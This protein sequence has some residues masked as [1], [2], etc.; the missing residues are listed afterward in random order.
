MN[1]LERVENPPDDIIGTVTEILDGDHGLYAVV[2]VRDFCVKWVTFSLADA[3]LEKRMLTEKD[4]PGYIVVLSDLVP[5]PRGWRAF[6]ARFFRPG[7]HAK[8]GQVVNDLVVVE[9]G[10]EINGS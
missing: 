7:D 4:G 2:A 6:K 3:W 9:K 10:G 1:S 8:F 5:K